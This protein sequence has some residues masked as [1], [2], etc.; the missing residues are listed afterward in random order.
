MSRCF[1][2]V[3]APIV[4]R[5]VLNKELNAIGRREASPSHYSRYSQVNLA[6]RILGNQM[7]TPTTCR[8]KNVYYYWPTGELSLTKAM[9]ALSGGIII[10]PRQY[11]SGR[12]KGW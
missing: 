3:Q 8:V 4:S 7:Y 12:I 10:P 2:G 5:R 6:S 9:R 1:L 11:T